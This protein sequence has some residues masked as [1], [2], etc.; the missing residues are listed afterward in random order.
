MFTSRLARQFLS[1]AALP[2]SRA[3]STSFRAFA[4]KVQQPAPAWSANSLVNQQFK[5]L[6]NASF[7]DQYLV[8]VFYPL[9][10]TFVCPTELLAFSD[11]INEF[12]ERN[13]AVVGVST[14][15]VFSHLAWTNLDRKKGGLGSDLQIPLVAD[16]NMKISSDYGVLI[17]GAGI[18]L[19]GLF[20][21]DKAGKLRVS[22]VNDLP[23]GRSVDETLRL[24]DAIQ[25]TEEHGEVCPANWTKGKETIKPSPDASKEYFE[26]VN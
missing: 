16:K 20:I 5:E 2:S 15:S 12:K 23:I 7:K 18:A 8:M 3:F 10:F 11:R 14:D 17:D 21:I 26:A 24:I 1:K 19:R 6:S 9:D 4:P 22:Q 13:V 25:F